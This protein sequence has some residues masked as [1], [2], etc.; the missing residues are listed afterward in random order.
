VV[1]YS[2]KNVISVVS[3]VLS[4]LGCHCYQQT[5]NVT[6]CSIFSYLLLFSASTD[7]TV[8][9]SGIH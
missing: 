5:L 9:C 8:L 7:N 3:A 4:E 1:H 2:Y 6:Y